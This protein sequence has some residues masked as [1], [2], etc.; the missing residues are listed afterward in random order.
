MERELNELKQGGKSVA[1]YTMKFNELVQYVV[2]GND[3]PT[4]AWKMKKYSFGHRADI[5]H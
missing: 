2:N 5:A 1:E 3:A 4:E